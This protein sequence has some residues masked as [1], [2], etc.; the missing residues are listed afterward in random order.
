M[1]RISVRNLTLNVL[2]VQ[3]S[4]I[5]NYIID[6][7]GAAYIKSLLQFTYNQCINIQTLAKTNL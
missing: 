5:R 6:K 3:D 1:I 4:D 2:R 7:T